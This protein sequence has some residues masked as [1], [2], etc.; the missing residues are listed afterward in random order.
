MV[1]K[2]V[3]PDSNGLVFNSA[4]TF[5]W[6][7]V[8]SGDLNNNGASSKCTDEQ[9]VVNTNSPSIAT[10]LSATTASIGDTVHDS[11]TLSGATSNAGGTV[12]YTVY[13]DSVFSTGA[14]N[15]GV[16]PSFPT[17]RSSDLGLVFNSA[18]TF[19]WQAVYSGDLN[20]NGA[21]SKCTDEQLVVN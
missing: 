21:S 17:R 1:N 18:G 16:K 14:R 11:S 7:A 6:Q 12:Q 19:F 5:F 10:I 9:L 8:Y 15:A 3:V 20:N 13:S 2:R 4:G